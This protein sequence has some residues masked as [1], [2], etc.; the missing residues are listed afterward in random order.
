MTRNGTGHHQNLSRFKRRTM[1]R[2][3]RD[4]TGPMRGKMGRGKGGRMK[5]SR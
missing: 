4:A 3:G 5:R 1:E 2:N